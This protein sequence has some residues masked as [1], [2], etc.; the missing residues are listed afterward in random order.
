MKHTL[1]A[2]AA[3]AMLVPAT[4]EAEVIAISAMAFNQFDPLPVDADPQAVNGTL[5]TAE[6]RNMYASVQFPKSGNK[7]CKVSLVY[8]DANNGEGITVRLF[9]KR[10][11]SGSDASLPAQLMTQ[12]VSAGNAGT[13]Q[14][15][16]NST[17]SFRTI[18][19]AKNF[20]FLELH[21]QNFNMQ[22]VGVQ[23]DQRSSCP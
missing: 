6:A 10:F 16:S 2:L 13:M 15:N 11:V 5:V 7:V 17:V 22:P 1:A 3:L 20:Y 9:R 14:R 12:V 23:I 8:S 18:D 4:A 21:I 19:N